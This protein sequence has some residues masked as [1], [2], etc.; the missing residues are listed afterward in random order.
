M[1][2]LKFHLKETCNYVVWSDSWKEWIPESIVWA[3]SESFPFAQNL[4]LDPSWKSGL[5]GSSCQIQ[6]CDW[7]YIY[8]RMEGF[9]Q[10]LQWADHELTYVLLVIAISQKRLGLQ[11]NQLGLAEMLSHSI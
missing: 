8:W 3:K 7:R 2:S 5:L 10:I 4:Y 1:D 9:A 11:V 6:S